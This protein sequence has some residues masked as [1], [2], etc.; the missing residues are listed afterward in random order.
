MKIFYYKT[1]LYGYLSQLKAEGK[2]IGLVP[3]MGA[4]HQGHLSLLDYIKASCDIRVCSVFVNPTQFNNPEDLEKYPRPIEHDIQLLE[5]NGCDVLFMPQVKEMYGDNESWSIDLDGLDEVLE[6]AFRPG[7][8]QGVTQIV[9]KL[10]DIVKP[11]V[12]CFGQKDYQQFLVIQ[13]MVDIFSLDI[14]LIQCPTIRE[15]DG[16][17]MSS[18]NVRL[19]P[20]GREKA[21]IIYQT[22][23]QFQNNIHHMGIA[24]A[25]EQAIKKL[26][27]SDGITF[28]YFE[29]C[30]SQTLKVLQSAEKGDKVVVLAAVWLEEVRLIDNILFTLEA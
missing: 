29:V 14:A 28:E 22:L 25:R 8:Y 13:K 26:K 20:Q 2:Q 3:T 9:K 23:L 6:G 21:L 17:A 11:D 24:E 12:A 10:F 16:L 1:D 30:N 18:R 4:L 15:E 7:H 5:E 27:E 19:S